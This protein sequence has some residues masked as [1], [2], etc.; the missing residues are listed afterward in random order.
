MS[1]HDQPVASSARKTTGEVYIPRPA[2]AGLC[3]TMTCIRCL[4]PRP[5]SALVTDTRMRHQK[6]CAGGCSK[7]VKP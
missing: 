1:G 7:E 2:S 4:R 6:R 5:L 3:N